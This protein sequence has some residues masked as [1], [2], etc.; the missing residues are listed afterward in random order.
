MNSYNSKIKA[1]LKN[2]SKLIE[3]ENKPA[4]TTNGWYQ[5]YKNPILT[6]AHTPIH[7]RYDLNEKTNPFLMERIGV[8]AVM[9]SG[10]IKWN[11]K[12]LL[13]ARVEGVD[14]KSFFA[15]AESPNGIDNFRFWDYPVTIPETDDPATNVYDMRL[16]QHEDGWIYGVFCTERRDPQADVNDLSSAIAS[17]GIARTKDLTSWERLPDLISSSQQRNVVLHP[18]FVNGKYALYTRPQDDFI[19]AGSGSGIGWALVDDILNAKVIEEKIIDKR[20]YHTI[21]EMKNGEGPAPLKTPQG[22]LHMAHGVRGCAAGL[23]YV[24]YMYMTSLEDPSELIASPGG[25]FMAPEGVERIGD[26]SNVLFNNGWIADE[27][28]TVFIYYASS[29]TRMHVA[30]STI[31]RLVDY[32]LNT[33]EDGFSSA[34][35][36]ETLK[37]QIKSNFIVLENL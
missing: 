35:S 6:A 24:L 9:N 25:Y 20:Y 26:V 37:K 28:G 29:D 16:T 7:W 31:E 13:I 5:R 18:E 11:D 21:K 10:A 32:C 23:R 3:R 4:S 14:R 33:P 2:Q 36:V 22:W 17:A 1:L 34:S 27:D 30:T 8:N 12:Y 15:I 19:D